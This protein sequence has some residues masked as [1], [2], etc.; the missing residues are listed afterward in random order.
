[1]NGH[2]RRGG[3]RSASMAV[4]SGRASS[5]SYLSRRTSTPGTRATRTETATAPTAE[6]PSYMV[7]L[8]ENRAREVGLA[9][10]RLRSFHVELR[11]YCDSNSFSITLAALAVSA[12]TEIILS[13][14][15]E[16]GPLNA[17]LQRSPMLCGV[18][19]S[20]V[21]RGFFSDTTGALYVDRLS[22]EKSADLALSSSVPRYLA[23]AACGALL[24]YI[25][26]CMDTTF[27]PRTLRIELRPNAG[28]LFMDLRSMSSLE[29]VSS[30]NHSPTKATRKQT[31]LGLLDHTKTQAGYH[32]LR[33][34][35]L[36]PPCDQPTFE[37]RQAV[38]AEVSASEDMYFPASAALEKFPDLEGL[39][40]RLTQRANRTV[41]PS[42]S[43][44]A[45]EASSSGSVGLC[46]S[47]VSSGGTDDVEVSQFQPPDMNLVRNVLLLKQGL[48]AIPNLVHALSGARSPLLLTVCETLRS[49]LLATLWDHIH[50]VI[51]E[52]AIC[53]GGTSEQQRLS[54]AFAVK[55]GV[56]GVLDLA[57]KSLTETLDDIRALVRKEKEDQRLDKLVMAFSAKRGYHMSLPVKGG[58]Q[59]AICSLPSSFVE[60]V[61]QGKR[62][63]VS[64]YPLMDLNNR[65]EKT[66]D[67]IWRL[68]N[69]ELGRVVSY[70]CS[71]TTMGALHRMCDAV[72]MTDALLGFVTHVSLREGY[73]RPVFTGI[74]GPI[75]IKQGR[76]PVLD[77]I[78]GEDCVPNDVFF[79]SPETNAMVITGVNGAG[80]SVYL[81]LVAL[82]C[83]MA[84]AGCPIPAGSARLRTIHRI[85]TRVGTS[86]SLERSESSFSL[87]MA[88]MAAILSGLPPVPN[89]RRV[90]NGSRGSSSRHQADSD[91]REG[92][93]EPSTQGVN[94]LIVIDELG[95]STSAVDGFAVTWAIME[96]LTRTPRT[97]TLLATHFASLCAL[98]LYEPS[99]AMFHLACAARVSAAEPDANSNIAGGPA[100]RGRPMAGAVLPIGDGANGALADAAQQ[101][102]REGL[103]A[104]GHNGVSPGGL[105]RAPDLRPTFK[106]IAGPCTTPGYGLSTAAAAGV[107]ASFIRDALAIRS[108][109]PAR[110]LEEMVNSGGPPDTSAARRMNPSLC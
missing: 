36:E 43:R 40:S 58:A 81:K 53:S 67:E 41:A 64:T 47:S 72:A 60:P 97:F 4:A 93:S 49:P 100:S 65:Y 82:L 86:D 12:P 20:F 25:E 31:L 96:R 44:A 55:P 88:E 87:E 68:S 28:I 52:E 30:L 107:P 109:L 22:V 76:H 105:S 75:D 84:Q 8:I 21:Q 46:A 99:V 19:R 94:S 54:G 48:S 90:T 38:V 95:R 17:A 45:S 14:T 62:I 110:V 7:A 3:I 26:Y 39:V 51:D 103:V 9:L 6:E 83:I 79:S 61:Q 80:K 50:E 42:L 74:D 98:R 71:P 33:R 69:R 56:N 63:H 24:R 16:K 29:L 15:S 104:G 108:Q 32:F 13:V 57:R 37:M 73:V 1:M 18:R 106:L 102:I 27:V 5:R 10:Y 91:A 59:A 70:A 11:Q 2:L 101:S 34:N 78:A 23:L 89:E 92:A 66:L 35:L 85:C 77:C